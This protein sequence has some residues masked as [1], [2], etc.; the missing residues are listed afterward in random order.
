MVSSLPSGSSLPGVSFQRTM[1]SL[2]R[3]IEIPAMDLDVVS[4]SRT[5]ARVLIRLPVAIRSR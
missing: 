2:Q 1:R 4:P 3:E 5:E